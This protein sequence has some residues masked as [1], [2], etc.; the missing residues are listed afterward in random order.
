VTDEAQYLDYG[1]LARAA[2]LVAALAK[3]I[4]DLPTAPALSVA[5]P[6]PRASCIQ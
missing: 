6:D 2:D 1:K 4:G 3:D 5:K